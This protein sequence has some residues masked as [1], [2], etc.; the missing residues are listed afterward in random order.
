MTGSDGASILLLGI[1]AYAVIGY[2]IVP[3]L[4]QRWKKSHPA[5]QA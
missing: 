5:S 3:T 1:L 4:Y 2:V